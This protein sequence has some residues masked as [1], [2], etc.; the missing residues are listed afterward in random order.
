MGRDKR[1]A[2]QTN[3]RGRHGNSYIKSTKNEIVRS[4]NGKRDV[5]VEHYRKLGMATTN[6]T[7]DA[8]LRRKS[9]RGQRRM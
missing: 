9:K 3:R 8:E 7:F 2:R 6:E 1:D 5:L 4:S